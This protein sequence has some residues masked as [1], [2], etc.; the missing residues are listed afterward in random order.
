MAEGER[1][2]VSAGQGVFVVEALVLPLISWSLA[3]RYHHC[4]PRLLLLRHHHHPHR[5]RRRRQGRL[6]IGGCISS[7]ECCG[8]GA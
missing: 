1:V 3:L 4:H 2:G 7:W 6:S 8:C 5:R